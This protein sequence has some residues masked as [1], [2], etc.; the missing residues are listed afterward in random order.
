MAERLFSP[1]VFT[2][3]DLGAFMNHQAEEVTTG[4]IWWSQKSPLGAL[5]AMRASVVSVSPDNFSLSLGAFKN[6]ALKDR[7]FL[8]CELEMKEKALNKKKEKSAFILQQS[9]CS[10]TNACTH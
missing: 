2:L 5:P 1:T 6:V 10:F 3:A 8:F 4:T 7:R 9:I